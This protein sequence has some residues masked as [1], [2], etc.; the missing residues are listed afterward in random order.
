MRSDRSAANAWHAATR[1][2]SRLPAGCSN[3][4]NGYSPLGAGVFDWFIH[5]LLPWLTVALVSAAAYTRLTR[6]SMLD[7]LGED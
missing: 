2:Q 1:K 5:M 3:A 4:T 7:V 6:A